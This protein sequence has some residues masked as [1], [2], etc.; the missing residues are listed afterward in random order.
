MV[1]IGSYKTTSEVVCDGLRL[2]QEK[3]PNSN[4]QQL[5]NLIEEG[6]NSG[7]A[8]KRSITERGLYSHK[9]LQNIDKCQFIGI[10][11]H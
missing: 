8:V 2:L 4:L 10:I 7:E 3:T 6:E 11:R 1:E 5:K 9:T